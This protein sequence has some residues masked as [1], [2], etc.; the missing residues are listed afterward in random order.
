M[1]DAALHFALRTLRQREAFITRRYAKLAGEY[2]KLFKVL[3]RVAPDEARK[4]KESP[5]EIAP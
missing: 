2:I 5:A 1:K 4:F 3:K